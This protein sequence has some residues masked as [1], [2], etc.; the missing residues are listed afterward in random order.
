MNR[1][2]IPGPWCDNL[3]NRPR[4]VGPY[5][6]PRPVRVNNPGTRSTL[7]GS[8]RVESRRP[9]HLHLNRLELVAEA[10]V[11]SFDQERHDLPDSAIDFMFRLDSPADRAASP[12]LE[13]G[14]ARTGLLVGIANRRPH[15]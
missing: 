3:P 1:T 15:R 12:D 4:I 7:P 14:N 2:R 10:T 6:R 9:S 13:V 5:C 8:G 11:V